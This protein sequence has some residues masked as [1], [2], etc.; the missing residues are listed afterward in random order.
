VRQLYRSVNLFYKVAVYF[1]VSYVD[2]ISHGLL[3]DVE[4]EPL[5][6]SLPQY[7]LWLAEVILRVVI[8][9]LLVVLYEVQDFPCLCVG[10]LE[11]VDVV[12]HY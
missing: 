10:R 4:R 11:Y 7:V 3:D 8:I 1:I 2:G 5:L 6:L 9:V 12:G